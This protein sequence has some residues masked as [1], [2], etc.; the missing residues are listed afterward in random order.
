[1][2]PPPSSSRPGPVIVFVTAL[3]PLAFVA[4]GAF[5]LMCSGPRVI[6]GLSARAWPEAPGQVVDAL[7]DEIDL[8]GR[9][10]G[11]KRWFEVRVSY[12]FDVAGRPQ[13]GDRVGLWPERRLAPQA[14]ELAASY[15]PGLPVRVYYDPSNPARSLRTARSAAVLGPWHA[16]ACRCSLSVCSC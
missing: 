14:K 8:G 9:G 2:Q 11:T 6:E 4:G 1:M 7:V 16:P 12:A 3:I 15:P 13:R 10:P 5:L